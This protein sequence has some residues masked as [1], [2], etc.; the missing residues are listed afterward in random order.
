MLLTALVVMFCKCAALSTGDEALEIKSKFYNG[1]IFKARFYMVDAK[2]K[3]KLK[4]V[5]FARLLADDFLQSDPLLANIGKR[6][7]VSLAV[8][9]PSEAEIE[10]FLKMKPAFEYAVLSDRNANKS[11]M[12]QN[13]IY[14][15]AFVIN[16]ENKIIW[17]GELIDL[18][19][20]LDKFEA[21]KYDL[22]VNRKINRYL[23]EM[24]NALR[25][26]SEYQLDRAARAILAL[27]PGN[28]A[29]LR[30]RLFAFEN[31]NQLEEAWK[32]LEEFRHKYPQEKHL[33]M[34]QIDLGARYV[35]LSNRAAQTADDFVKAKLGDNNDRLLLAWLLLS[36][37]NFDSDALNSSEKLLNTLSEESF[38]GM[39]M[40]QALFNRSWAL[41]Y[42][43][44]CDISEAVK[45]QSRACA[46]SDTQENRKIL[47]YYQSLMKK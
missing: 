35:Q 31:T 9:T 44:K 33:Y 17:D 10:P 11:Y 45:K 12:E 37:Y 46:V 26:G 7:G 22:E 2:N 4:I 47:K 8:V 36:Q 32:F 16:Y 20:M 1:K 38:K 40:Q 21:G 3:N 39:P 5:V 28:L 41:L 43:K 24:Q 13:I 6:K 23:A 25:G 30:M 14:P 27:D 19:D 29:C 15:R 42:Y 34:L 18:P